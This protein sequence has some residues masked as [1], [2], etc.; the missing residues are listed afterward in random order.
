MGTFRCVIVLVAVLAL[1]PLA[2]AGPTE[3]VDAVVDHWVTAFNSNDVGA[4][5]NLYAPDAILLGTAGL[6]LHEGSEAVRSYFDR[7]AKSGDKV[8]INNRKIVVLDGN[9]AYVTGFYEFESTRNGETRKSTAGFTMVL[10]KR[11]DDWLISHHHSS[12][13]SLAPLTL[14][15]RRG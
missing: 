14:P 9:V 13:R 12:R 11:S 4:L 7:L 6:S 2:C 1:A 5:A 3:D 10:V 15:L 8:S